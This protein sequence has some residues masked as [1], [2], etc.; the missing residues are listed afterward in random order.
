LSLKSKRQL[1]TRGR[2]SSFWS[3]GPHERFLSLFAPVLLLL[4]AL[5]SNRLLELGVRLSASRVLRELGALGLAAA[6]VVGWGP[7]QEPRLTCRRG[8]PPRTRGPQR[9]L[10]VEPTRRDP[11]TVF[12]DLTPYEGKRASLR[13]FDKSP[14]QHIQ[15]DRILLWR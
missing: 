14:R 4:A 9:R 13:V 10:A 6:A 2:P 1:S 7:F 5:G 11:T 3:I 15:V 12:W 8:S